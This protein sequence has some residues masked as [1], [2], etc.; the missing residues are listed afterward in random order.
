MAD[1]EE[2]WGQSQMESPILNDLAQDTDSFQFFQK[3]DL[4]DAGLLPVPPV[5]VKRKQTSVVNLIDFQACNQLAAQIEDSLSMCLTNGQGSP[6]APAAAAAIQRLL[7]AEIQRREQEQLERRL[8]EQEQLQRLLDRQRRREL[9]RAAFLLWRDAARQEK[10]D[11]LFQ[12]NVKLR[13]K[14]KKYV[15]FL[16]RDAT[17]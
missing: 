5:A 2:F 4:A 16:A 1:S 13:V 10:Y 11:A 9:A 14:M 7:Q 8:A 17:V 15:N 3:Q 6:V 12:D